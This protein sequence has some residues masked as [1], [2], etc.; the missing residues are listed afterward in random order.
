[1]D[2]T[3]DII[4]GVVQEMTGQILDHVPTPKTIGEWTIQLGVICDIQTGEAMH[5]NENLSLG[6]DSTPIDGD[7]L[8]EI[9]I[10]LPG[11][12]ITS[13]VLQVVNMPGG[14][15]RDYCDSIKTALTDI[16]TIY[17]EFENLDPIKTKVKMLSN[18]TNVLT[19]RVNTNHACTQLLMHELEI[20][21]IETNCNVHVADGLG[22]G[23]IKASKKF[24]SQNQ[25]ESNVKGSGARII[26][27]IQLVCK[28]RYKQV[29]GDP[30]GFKNMLI[31]DELPLSFV[32]RYVGNRFNIIFRL[33]C[34][35]I[36][37]R[38][39][40]MTY[41]QTECPC[42]KVRTVLLEDFNN[43]DICVQLLAYGYIAKF[44]TNPYIKTIYGG[45]L[46]NL[47][48]IPYVQTCLDNI[49][50]YI[51]DPT[52]LFSATNDVFGK[53][54]SDLFNMRSILQSH[55][56]TPQL[57]NH[58]KQILQEFEI[59]LVR[60]LKNYVDGGKLTK[61]T[62]AQK[63][64]CKSA[65]GHAMFAEGVLSVVTSQKARC[66]NARTIYVETK[67]KTKKQNP[68]VA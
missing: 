26:N 34:V 36:C 24:D 7:H 28:V 5:E 14:T 53:E 40:F 35:F 58:L 50:K 12:P 44:V 43:P 22:K 52:V 6:W 51:Q 25:V 20:N 17:S 56:K 65:A 11:P 30:K 29:V 13:H 48:P 23:A 18:I 57:S 10:S 1:M 15:A 27:F 49:R 54:V 66:P 3:G 42:K 45:N 55:E 16:S 32:P 37:Y 39:M 64:Q 62:D 8:N 31:K 41:M 4:Q 47:E 33:A 9:H 68:S 2:G 61:L 19:D 38:E 67:V 21:V 46:T 60:Q 59:V 63:N